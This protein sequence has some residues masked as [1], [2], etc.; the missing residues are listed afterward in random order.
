MAT[1]RALDV[2]P[3]IMKRR[4]RLDAGDGV[5]TRQSRELLCCKK[6]CLMALALSSGAYCAFS[7]PKVDMKK[8]VTS[9]EAFPVMSWEFRRF[10]DIT[11]ENE[12]ITNWVELGINRP[13]TPY[14]DAKTDKNRFRKFLDKCY[15]AGLRVYVFDK[16][17]SMMPGIH[18]GYG[19]SV[20]FGKGED[21]YRDMCREVK[22]D[23][24]S[25][26]AVE[27]FYIYDEP[28]KGLAETLY[29]RI[30]IFREE[31]PGKVPFLNLLPWFEGETSKEMLDGGTLV[32]YLEQVRSKTGLGL[33]SYDCYCHMN[34][35]ERNQGLY[36]Y[37]DNLRG[38]SEFGKKTGCKW[39]VILL[40]APHF[41]FRIDGEHDFR[42][43]ISTAVAMGASS[44]GWF[45]PDVTDSQ[46]SN[47]RRAPID[48]LGMRTESFGW[49]Q[50]EMYAFHRRF[51]V[52]FRQL[53]FE[54]AGLVG[55][56]YGGIPPF[57][58][59]ADFACEGSPMLFSFFHDKSG[60]RYVAMVNLN[61][62][63]NANI[64]TCYIFGNGIK[65][66]RRDVDQWR[67]IVPNSIKDGKIY[68]EFWFAAGQMELFRLNR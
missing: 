51:G 53:T 39:N 14:V 28:T 58:G 29:S 5:S 27:G 32:D 19:D 55:K 47:G 24:A 48:P 59:D 21:E 35:K 37:F 46:D 65:P 40:C 60:I 22:A 63:E 44:I 68:G 49:L 2:K 23:W 38:W 4:V 34:K 64:N 57:K 45:V 13:F 11:D 8:F 9:L 52:V 17:V 43:Q 1:E 36:E 16:R 26:P 31:V 66:Y 67:K 10:E 3:H 41:N 61:Q 54:Y 12:K 6:V 15:K 56:D 20:L 62:D 30:R 7:S 33:L 18:A 42:W 50:R 25:H